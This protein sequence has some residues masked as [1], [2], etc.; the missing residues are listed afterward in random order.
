MFTPIAKRDMVECH[1][2]KQSLI[3]YTIIDPSDL[4]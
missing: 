3:Y 4:I 2:S 1:V